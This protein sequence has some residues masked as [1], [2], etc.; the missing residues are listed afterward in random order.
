MEQTVG[1]TFNDIRF[2][3]FNF[4]EYLALLRSNHSCPQE[5][6]IE[7]EKERGTAVIRKIV[8]ANFRK[9]QI[10]EEDFIFVQYFL[11]ERGDFI[12]EGVGRVQKEGTRFPVESAKCQKLIKKIR[13][14]CWPDAAKSDSCRPENVAQDVQ[15]VGNKPVKGERKRTPSFTWNWDATFIQT[16]L[17]E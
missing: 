14:L 16:S 13:R 10:S 8:D 17:F 12:A 9:V 3:R 5:K 4:D 1:L 7:K 6:T 2:L 11:E 15:E